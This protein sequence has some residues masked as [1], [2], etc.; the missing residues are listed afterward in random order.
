MSRVQSRANASKLP[1]VDNDVMWN[2]AINDFEASGHDG[3]E[4]LVGDESNL[5]D[6]AQ[7]LKMYTCVYEPNITF[8]FFS[9]AMNSCVN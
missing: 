6:V 2:H 7:L 4:S 8:A 3:Q 9:N 1:I 5:E